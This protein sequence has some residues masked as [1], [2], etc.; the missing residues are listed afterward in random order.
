MIRNNE[1]IQIKGDKFPIGAFLDEELSKFANNEMDLKKGDMLYIFSDGYV[2]Q[3]GGDTGRKFLIKH[4]KDLLLE[5]HQKP[6]EDQKTH[7]LETFEAWKKGYP[8]IDDIL[9]I[10]IKI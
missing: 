10:G 6:L 8:Q 9:I 5:I 2:D 4:F 1:L 7:L 3:F